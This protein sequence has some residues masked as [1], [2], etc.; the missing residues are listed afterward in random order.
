MRSSSPAAMVRSPF[1]PRTR[2]GLPAAVQTWPPTGPP[3]I[4]VAARAR[5]DH[6]PAAASA[7]PATNS[8]PHLRLRTTARWPDGRRMARKTRAA[9]AD[10]SPVAADL[11]RVGLPSNPYTGT[12]DIFAFDDSMIV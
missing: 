9:A 5:A 3:S 2:Y 4:I 7:K 6:A 1:T 10:Q 11:A 8:A 12:D